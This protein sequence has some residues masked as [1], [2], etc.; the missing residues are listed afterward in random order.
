MSD[1][2]SNVATIFLEWY[3]PT[4]WSY[5]CGVVQGRLVTCRA[6]IKACARCR[7][8]MRSW[9]NSCLLHIL[10]WLLI[11]RSCLNGLRCVVVEMHV[12]RA[13]IM[14]TDM[15]SQHFERESQTIQEDVVA[16]SSPFVPT[17]STSLD[18]DYHAQRTICRIDDLRAG[19]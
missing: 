9:I 17:L 16:S 7:I 2:Y 12:F 6:A 13:R 4:S 18:S 1:I 8:G 15:V 19:I 3:D 5:R 14:R 11:S 10:T